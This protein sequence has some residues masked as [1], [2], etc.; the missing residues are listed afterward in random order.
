MRCL[1]DAHVYS[2]RS[3][4]QAYPKAQR[5]FGV[6]VATQQEANLSLPM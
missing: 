4:Y 2:F 5:F 3:R 6:S 1:P